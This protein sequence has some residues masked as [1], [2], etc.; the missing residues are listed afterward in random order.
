MSFAQ[1]TERQLLEEYFGNLSFLKI[2]SD[3]R[4]GQLIKDFTVLRA[5]KGD[6]V[7]YQSDP[8]TDLYIMI[9]G[10]VKASLQN[11]EGQELVLATFR[12][13]DFFGE[14]SLL[15]GRPRSAT[16]IA[17]D[18]SVLAVLRRE[19]FLEAVK[20]DPMMAIELLSALVQRLRMTDEMV[21]SIAFL[22]VGQRLLRLFHLMAEAENDKTS[23]D[24]LKVKKLT[25]KELAARTGSSREA[26]S[27]AMKVL[28]FKN[29]IKEGDGCILVSRNAGKR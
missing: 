14:M 28:S 12:K 3:T 7:F 23:D 11:D 21:E 13:G 1:R 22:D 25:H 10:A 18:D 9:E 8:S 16:V 2:L 6:V 20:G 17:V 27:K 4:I 24:F 5:G 19:K 15:D 29:V 26:V